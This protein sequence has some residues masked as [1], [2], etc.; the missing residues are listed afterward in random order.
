[1]GGFYVQDRWRIKPSLTLNYGLRWEIQGPMH[2]VKGLTAAPDLASLFGPSTK[3]FTPGVLS[4]NNNPTVEVGR[5]AYKTDWLNLA[6]N[7]G[8]A[9][10][11]TR[12]EGLLGKLLG[13]GKTVIRGSYG[14]IVYDEGT[15][16]FAQNLGPNAGKQINGTPRSYRGSRGRPHC[17]RSTRSR[18]IV[19][20]PLT[21]SSFAFTTT[22]TRR[23]STR[24]T[25]PSSGPSMDS[26]PRCVLPTPSI[27]ASAVQRELWQEHRAGGS[28][29]GQPVAALLAH[30]QSE[31]S[32]HLRKRI[33]AG[34]QERADSNLAI[35][36]AAGVNQLRRTAD[37]RA[38]WLCRSSTRLSARAALRRHSPRVRDMRQRRLHRQ[39]AKR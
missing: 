7:F 12:T 10:N 11:P 6:P 27:G 16:F 37:S 5:A 20:N 19:A 39:P 30:Q 29:R 8:F 13:G 28:I 17:R 35:N 2:D 32:Q 9:W 23:S 38:R 25:R 36:Q 26:I 31:R 33:P 1:M 21:A 22:T 24:R 15:Q 3:L 34:I 4:G 14:L 18:D